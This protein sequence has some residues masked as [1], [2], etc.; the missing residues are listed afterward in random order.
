MLLRQLRFAHLQHARQRRADAGAFAW[1][2]S[3]PARALAGRRKL[4]PV[5]SGRGCGGP[6][7]LARGALPV[8][9]FGWARCLRRAEMGWSACRLLWAGA[10]WASSPHPFQS[11]ER[12]EHS[13]R[14][15]RSCRMGL[16]GCGRSSLGS[17]R[18]STRS[19]SCSRGPACT[20]DRGRRSVA[21]CIETVCRRCIEWASLWTN[22]KSG[23]GQERSWTI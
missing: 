6:S 15:R 4:G 16:L 18:S 21:P 2:S 8:A 17:T 1:R 19:R 20:D 3:P 5:G 9:A 10:G 13:S 12:F 14:S 22:S 11:D 23:G 7:A